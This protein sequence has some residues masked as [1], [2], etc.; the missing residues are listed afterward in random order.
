MNTYDSFNRQVLRP[1]IESAQFALWA[2]GDR[3]RSAGL[4][5]SFGTVGDGFDNT[6]MESFWSSMQIEQLI[7]KRWK[8]GVELSNEMF[9]YIEVSSSRQRRHSKPNYAPP[10][11]LASS[12]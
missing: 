9:D 8:T 3:N 2:F 11:E 5:P 1:L 6:M 4:I 10:I 7:R 12:P